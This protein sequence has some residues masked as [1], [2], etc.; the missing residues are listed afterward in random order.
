MGCAKKWQRLLL[1]GCAA[2]TSGGD[3]YGVHQ[4]GEGGCSGGAG[5]SCLDW[6]DPPA[7]R[8]HQSFLSSIYH[9][10]DG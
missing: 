3:G 10:A 9:F 6:A 2:A 8:V 7:A 4:S 1:G 5:N